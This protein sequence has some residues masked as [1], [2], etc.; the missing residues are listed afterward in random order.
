MNLLRKLLL[1]IMSNWHNKDLSLPK[2][3]HGT[4]ELRN[5][6]LCTKV[7]LKVELLIFNYFLFYY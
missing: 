6:L 2:I 3:I 4:I 5:F 7:V 1:K